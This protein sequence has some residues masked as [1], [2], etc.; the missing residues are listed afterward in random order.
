MKD[1]SFQRFSQ[2][3]QILKKLNIQ[4]KLTVILRHMLLPQIKGLLG[5]IMKIELLSFLTLQSL[6]IVMNGK[7]LLILVFLMGMEELIVQIF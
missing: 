3:Y 6:S 4:L 5:I 7:K 1:H 2:R